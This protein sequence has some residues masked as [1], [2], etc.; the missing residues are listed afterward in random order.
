[1]TNKA[2]NLVNDMFESNVDVLLY[3]KDRWQDEKDYE[4][5]K[6]YI[7]QVKKFVESKGFVFVKMTK[8]FCITMKYLNTLITMKLGADVAEIKFLEFPSSNRN[9]GVSK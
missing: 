1:M 9:R 2:Q 6:N 3:L 4:D 8:G 7:S 5:F